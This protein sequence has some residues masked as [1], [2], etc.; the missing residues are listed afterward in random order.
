MLAVLAGLAILAGAAASASTA[1]SQAA[2]GTLNLNAALRLVS[3]SVS[4]RPACCR[5]HVLQN[6]PARAPL[7]DIAVH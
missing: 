2:T 3:V 7:N 1:R 6:A 4:A 5:E